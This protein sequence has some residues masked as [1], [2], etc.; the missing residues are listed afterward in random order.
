MSISEDYK[1]VDLPFSPRKFLEISHKGEE[2]TKFE[3]GNL[4]ELI[5]QVDETDE[6]LEKPLLYLKM[7][8]ECA[9]S[10][11]STQ[12]YEISEIIDR[13][14]L[15]F[16]LLDHIQTSSDKMFMHIIDILVL[17]YLIGNLDFDI[18]SEEKR[19]LL[20]DIILERS[21]AY[22]YN[23][24]Y[25][26]AAIISKNN[27][28]FD[29]N[30][31]MNLAYQERLDDIVWFLVESFKTNPRNFKEF[32]QFF[33]QML[34][35]NRYP[36]LYGIFFCTLYDLQFTNE[37]ATLNIFDEFVNDENDECHEILNS[38]IKIVIYGS[39]DDSFNFF[40]T[41][42]HQ[43]DVDLKI[44]YYLVKH[45]PSRARKII[46]DEEIEMIKELSVD[47]KF[48]DKQYA[49]KLLIKLVE[50]SIVDC[51][52]VL[53]IFNEIFHYYENYQV[54]ERIIN[55]VTDKL[56]QTYGS[57]EISQSLTFFGNIEECFD[58]IIEDADDSLI[59]S[60]EEL[61]KAINDI[62][63]EQSL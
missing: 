2:P 21:I 30:S 10:G 53:P 23:S 60:I 38:L 58:D 31:I 3:E 54:L 29:E 13:N 57:E 63:L 56:R 48:D 24:F 17:M 28:E 6:S 41:K 16:F 50:Y 11:D 9:Y 47:G 39:N 19:K 45:C 51:I 8:V 36:S 61:D 37:I 14:D 33:I 55:L 5:S 44:K 26:L 7:Y 42:F 32:E 43:I 12:K 34:E 18:L 52:S 59:E 62:K 49:I 20:F 40:M 35:T 46:T 25:L 27:F 22:L 4:L 1:S 15:L